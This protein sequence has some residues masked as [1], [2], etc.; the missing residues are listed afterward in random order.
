M[1]K[2]NGLKSITLVI[3]SLFVAH[4]F[5]SQDNGQFTDARD[6]RTY[7]TVKIGKQVW[8]AENLYFSNP[9]IT[10]FLYNNNQNLINLVICMIGLPLVKFALRVGNSPVMLNF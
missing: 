7:K 5:Y 9:N 8:M 3:Y 2:S 10:Y 1:L 6:G 4:F